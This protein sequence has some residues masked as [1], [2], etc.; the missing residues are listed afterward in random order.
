MEL[1]KPESKS[2]INKSP[3]KEGIK[4]I[5]KNINNSEKDIRFI[6][7]N[8]YL[9]DYNYYN[10]NIL[11]MNKLREEKIKEH[12]KSIDNN[13]KSNLMPKMLYFNKFFHSKPKILQKYNSRISP[14]PKT[15]ENSRIQKS[16][17]KNKKNE[18]YE[19]I[20]LAVESESIEQNSKRHIKKTIKVFDDLLQYVDGFKIKNREKR[21]RLLLSENNKD[22]NNIDESKGDT[23]GDDDEEDINVENYN[24]DEYRQKYKDEKKKHIENISKTEID[25]DSPNMIN[26]IDMQIKTNLLLNDNNNDNIYIT[27]NFRTVENSKNKSINDNQIKKNYVERNKLNKIHDKK[28]LTINDMILISDDSLAN[29]IKNI[30]KNFKKDL[31]FNTNNFGKFKFTELGL[32]Y[33]SSFDKYKK[34]PDYKGNDLEERRMFNYKTKITNPRYNYTNIGSFNDKFNKDLSKISNYYGKEQA[35]GRFIRNPL[36]SMFSKYIPNYEQYKDLKFIENR[37]TSG[38]KYMFRLKSLINNRKNNFDRLADNIYKKEHKAGY[39]E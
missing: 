11:K 21:L 17:S 19:K 24:F 15:S 23:D 6:Q 32:H 28:N 39:F 9:N 35:K 1:N 30:R 34:F 16:I 38:N 18:E 10:K 14:N 29:K 12:K 4:S 22:N 3:I 8:F 2:N 36:I 33:P 20:E 7:T 27:Q 25:L 5:K 13:K 31:Y 37:Y 26:Y